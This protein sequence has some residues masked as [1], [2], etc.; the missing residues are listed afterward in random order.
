MDNAYI[1]SARLS[2]RERM[3]G[4]IYQLITV[5]NI[6]EGGELVMPLLSDLPYP[7]LALPNSGLY[8]FVSSNG[9]DKLLWGSPSLN[10]RQNP[11]PF[12]LHLGE[13]RW[14]EVKMEDG[15]DYYLLGFGFQRSLKFGNNSYNFHLMT[16]L[17]PLNKQVYLYRR[18]LWGGLATTAMLLLMT[19]ILVLRWGLNPLRKV[20]Q[21]LS[22]IETGERN[23]IKDDYPREVKQLTD[24]INILLSQERTRQTRYRNALADLSHSLKTPLAVLL[25]GLMSLIRYLKLCLNKAPA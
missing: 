14:Q 22:L 5:S 16:E 17:M 11:K 24:K 4:Q 19:Q 20:G 9:S 3:L 15:K 23:Q 8:A 10:K 7:Q 1:E 2:L 6:N 12:T 21:E 13:K 18:K 25:G